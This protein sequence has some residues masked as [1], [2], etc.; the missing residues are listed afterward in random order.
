M[1]K[2]EKIPSN[3]KRDV[4][5][6]GLISFV[7]SF[8]CVCFIACR[9]NTPQYFDKL[10][11][12]YTAV[13]GGNKT[14]EILAFWTGLV[15]SIM[16]FSLYVFKLRGMKKEAEGEADKNHTKVRLDEYQLLLLGLTVG[17]FIFQG[18]SVPSIVLCLDAVALASWFL[19]RETG[20]LLSL[21]MELLLGGMGIVAAVRIFVIAL[22][23][24]LV[25]QI[26]MLFVLLLIVFLEK[27]GKAVSFSAG[28]LSQLFVPFSLIVY[29]TNRYI[30]QN[31][32][33][34]ISVPVLYAVLI[35]A[36][37]GALF[38]Y[39]VRFFRKNWSAGKAA[40]ILPENR[41]SRA[42]IMS[43]A[44]FF[45][46]PGVS[47]I[48]NDMHHP[49]E[50]VISYLEVFQEH[51][52]LYRDYFPVSG[53][54]SIV[55]GFVNEI[56]GGAYSEIIFTSA[57]LVLG[58]SFLLGFLC[59]HRIKK[60]YLLLLCLCFS[61]CQ[62][63]M[64]IRTQFLLP[65]LLFLLT[66]KK[67]SGTT[68]F[69]GV[70]LTMFMGLYYPLYGVAFGTAALPWFVYLIYELIRNHKM[71]ETF[72]Q[73]RAWMKWVLLL[74][75]IALL[76]PLF[77]G[78]AKQT[79]LYSSQS[80]L[81]DGITLI[82]NTVPD[83]FMPYLSVIPGA[84]LLFY[85]MLWFGIPFFFML[86]LV[87]P[88]FLAYKENGQK[89]WKNKAVYLPLGAVCMILISFSYTINRADGGAISRT[90][91]ILMPMVP[92]VLLIYQRTNSRRDENRAAAM[93]VAGMA[94]TAFLF[95]GNHT[96]NLDKIF[97]TAYDVGENRDYMSGMSSSR[98]GESF[99]PVEYALSLEKVSAAK[100]F[101]QTVDE[102]IYYFGAKNGENYIEEFAA[103][104]QP[105][106]VAMKSF[107]TTRANL[108]ALAGKKCVIFGGYRTDWQYYFVYQLLTSD[109]FYY[110]KDF[111]CFVTK[112]LAELIPE[113]LSDK[114][115]CGWKQESLQNLPDSLGRSY[116]AYGADWVEHTD[117]AVK[118]AQMQQGKVSGDEKQPDY[119]TMY[120]LELNQRLKGDEADFLYMELA[121][122]QIEKEE[123]RSLEQFLQ[124]ASPHEGLK[125][126]VE[127]EA[128]GQTESM[129]CKYAN[130]RL[131]IPL[132]SNA[133]WLTMEHGEISVIIY[134]SEHAYQCEIKNI[135]F[136]KSD[137]YK[138]LW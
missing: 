65:M 19:K 134:G 127:F 27:D 116:L 40:E 60:D 93:L 107:D 83:S 4:I 121:D 129:N 71:K 120:L 113:K 63:F 82:G 118:G 34:R 123:S 69:W 62:P 105:S 95:N 45:A 91:Y 1:G 28:L 58:V 130:G 50:I 36:G 136:L 8:L 101:F 74:I 72:V 81:A 25:I 108:D 131:L 13:L 125:V 92:V 80:V 5:A 96:G 137:A 106:V 73:K 14:N 70:V 119:Y 66:G 12:E 21:Y 86:S 54:F 68:L 30:Y 109:T 43:A 29:F 112:E 59:F 117:Y 32:Y 46:F 39:N 48:L 49:G 61:F 97:T 37:I 77:Y 51:L 31:K 24:A 103:P 33:M 122:N 89:M 76:L 84:R 47:R 38:L 67:K 64:S 79:I 41:I 138:L 57:L 104:G 114:S 56:M 111:D 128:D 18:L 44:G 53:L 17:L 52:K 90:A 3:W 85:Y 22:I 102:N 124:Q 11:I 35:S 15:F 23:P 42:T 75:C 20:E 16:L 98:L 7:T 100:E 99:V 87:C 135:Q 78:M 126:A 26:F 115:E 2:D 132:G 6:V 110:V 10:I 133:K 9:K 55:T 88:L 94:V